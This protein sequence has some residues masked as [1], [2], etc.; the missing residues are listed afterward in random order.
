MYVQHNYTKGKAGKIYSATFLCSKYRE[1]GKVK[2]KVLANLSQLPEKT[3]QGIER[4]LKSEKE[5]VIPLQEIAISKCVD[6]GYLFFTHQIMKQLR[7]DEVLSKTI[8]AQHVPLI[9]S[10]IL[11]K[12]ITGGSKLSIYNWLQRESYAIDLLGIKLDK[13][14]V[15]DLYNSLGVLPH[16]QKKI[17]K[18]WF[19]YHKASTRRIFLYD[20]T[21]TYFEGTQNELAAFGYNREGKKGKMQI[22]LGLVTDE[23]G[24]PLKAEVFEGNTLDSNTVSEQ[25]KSLRKEFGIEEVI[26]VGDRGMRIMYHLEEDEEL[27]N[28]NIDF[29]TGLTRSAIEELIDRNIIQLDLFSKELVEVSEG[30]KRYIL[31]VNP[32]LEE[33]GKLYLQHQQTRAK[34]L[35][36]Q[37]E[38]SWK[39]RRYL[40]MENQL[41]LEEGKTKNKKLKTQFNE[42][43]IDRYKRRVNRVMDECKMTKYYTINTIDNERFVVDFNQ[44]TFQQTE[45]LCGKYVVCTSVKA[46]ALNKEEVR[47]KYK[48]LQ[49][50]E[51]A[52]RDLKSDNINIRPVYHRNEKQTRGHVQ[53]C[54]FAYAI[55]KELE[56]KLYPFLKEYNQ[57]NKTQLSFHDMIQEINS[58]KLCELKIGKE[59]KILMYPELSS[60]QKKIFQL[61]NIN[62]KNMVA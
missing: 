38:T 5:G 51:H 43:D 50:V 9:E 45:S 59:Q 8:P 27:K 53:V 26:F 3:I 23:D 6:Y 2:T 25:I 16:Y 49:Q 32:E 19:Q 29:I 4:L 30:E 40:N 47:E 11:G 1:N 10:M 31:S 22:C 62:P 46:D 34:E 37:I 13:L 56:N 33:S 24:F 58:V 28:M 41:K 61:F 14:K 48:N 20:I 57:Q 21:S 44:E 18:K 36:K 39:D 35:L 42:K 17:E 7:I 12:L 60:M 55:I 52:F 54:I 15:D